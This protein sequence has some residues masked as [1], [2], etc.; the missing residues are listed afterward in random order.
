MI[1][2]FRFDLMGIHDIETMNAIRAAV[3]GIDPSVL[4]YGEGWAA[5]A[6]LYDGSLLA[7]KANTWE[8]PGIA[9]FSDEMRDAL[10]GP[11][12]DNSKAGFARP[13]GERQVRCSR[14]CTASGRGLL[15]GQLFRHMLGL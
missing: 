8:M 11:F 9:A 2:G 3:S 5:S 13:R 6:P 12:S 15:S 4:I 10:R 14:S 7:M 1:D